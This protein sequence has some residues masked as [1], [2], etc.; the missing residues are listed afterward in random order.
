L[1]REDQGGSD[2][3]AH[4]PDF[5]ISLAILDPCVDVTGEAEHAEGEGHRREEESQEEHEAPGLAA[6][7]GDE[8][9]V[10]NPE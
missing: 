4:A 6:I 8:Y 3:V 10:W 9:M 7:P 2:L 5:E 1:D